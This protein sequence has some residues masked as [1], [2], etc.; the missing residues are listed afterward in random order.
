M[1]NFNNYQDVTQGVLSPKELQAIE[2]TKIV[3][4]RIDLGKNMVSFENA[5]LSAIKAKWEKATKEILSKIP[6]IAED[7][8]LSNGKQKNIF[9]IN[10]N[11]KSESYF[12]QAA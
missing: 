5:D 7:V 2:W 12:A 10:S 4:L 9:D 3:I 6:E 8:I 1:K 11:L